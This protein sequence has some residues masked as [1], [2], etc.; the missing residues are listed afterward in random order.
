MEE[1]SL[2]AV[3][4]THLAAIDVT[5]GDAASFL[6]G[7]FCNDVAALTSPGGQR[8]GFC[9]PK[10]RLL[11]AP[12]LQQLTH[13]HRLLLPLDLVGSFLQRIRMF[14]LRADV[15]FTLRE[16]LGVFGVYDDEAAVLASIGLSLPRTPGEVTEHDHTS[17]MLW[18]QHE[19]ERWLV[20]A[21]ISQLGDVPADDIGRWRLDDIRAGLPSVVAATRE[22][23]V[24]QMLNFAAVEALSFTKGC[25]PGQ[26]IVARTQ[27]LGKLKKHMQRFVAAS[28]ELPQPGDVL[29]EAGS[30]DAGEVV[31]AMR[32][33]DGG[34]EALVVVRKERA[35]DA[36]LPL[37]GGGAALPAS[38]P[39]PL[40]SAD[41]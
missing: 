8:T 1:N 41:T 40:E 25:Y 14:V 5:G 20:V 2:A 32:T 37:E 16:D 38:L 4:L 34:I 10:G 12:V 26:E 36:S 28:G 15:T 7:Q 9:S 35:A 24:P 33:G 6:Q 30:A 39:Y 29:G 27:Y 22:A 3:R 21:P 17:A 23:F 31:D 11:A 13:H 19:R 18:D